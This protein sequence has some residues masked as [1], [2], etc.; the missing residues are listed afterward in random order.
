M[1]TEIADSRW[2]M[3]LKAV[4][5]HLALQKGYRKTAGK[6]P[7]AFRKPLGNF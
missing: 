2:E 6:C 3:L 1:L 4:G 5:Q 7:N